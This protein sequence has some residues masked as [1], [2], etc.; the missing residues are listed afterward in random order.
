MRLLSKELQKMA[1]S[2]NSCV[3]GHRERHRVT[4]PTQQSLN[5]SLSCVL[6]KSTSRKDGWTNFFL[7]LSDKNTIPFLLE[8]NSIVLAQ[9]GKILPTHS[10]SNFHS[11]R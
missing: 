3:E 8:R 4:L 7:F 5:I 6:T 11:V 1:L 2:Q 9:Q 10:S